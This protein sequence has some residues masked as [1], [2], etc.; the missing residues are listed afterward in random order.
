MRDHFKRQIH[1]FQW[2]RQNDMCYLDTF[3][4]SLVSVRG[5]CC[6]NLFAWK[7]SKYDHPVLMQRRSQALTSLNNCLAKCGIMTHL[8]SDNAPEF[9]SEQF[10]ARLKQICVDQSFSETEHQNENIAEPRG[11]NLKAATVHTLT[12][13]GAPT[14][15]WCFCLEYTALV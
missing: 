2:P 12:T 4:S 10:T 13:T 1:A 11:G 8:K 3:F 14:V 9:N 5:Y 7:D 6:F 15:F